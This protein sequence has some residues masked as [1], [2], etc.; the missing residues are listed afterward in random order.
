MKTNLSFNEKIE[1]GSCAWFTKPR[2]KNR[3]IPTLAK[4]HTDHAVHK[5]H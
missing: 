4:M 5:G 1:N 3:T 2:E